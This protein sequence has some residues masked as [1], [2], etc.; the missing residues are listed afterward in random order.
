MRLATWN[1]NSIKVRLPRLLEFL[2]EHTPEVVCLQEV[3]AS[4]D[5]P[6][7]AELQSAGY[8][9]TA[10]CGGRW[11]GVALL[12]RAP[13]ALI[14]VRR[15]LPGEPRPDEARWVETVLSGA[16]HHLDGARVASVY[17]PNGRAPGTPAFADKLAFLDAMI[18]RVAG[19]ARPVTLLAGDL[20]VA[21]ADIDL[22]DPAA[23]PGATHVTDDERERLAAVRD[24]GGLTDV[25]RHLAPGTPGFT[26]WD[27]RA[28]AFHRNRGMRI[29][30]WLATKDVIARATACGID[31][32]YRKGPKPSDHAPLLLHLG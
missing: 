25:Y 29:D 1:V 20:N 17:V 12:V 3:K 26:W 4:P 30:H 10:H 18:E 24:A 7:R 6:P 14:D 2:T 13:L 31:R 11:N 21:P 23:F 22:Y 9:V 32:D 16:G 5:A 8:H 15:G 27:Y 19:T 28:G